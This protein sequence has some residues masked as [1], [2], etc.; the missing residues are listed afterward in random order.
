[1]PLHAVLIGTAIYMLQQ[2]T[3]S[4]CELTYTD[5]EVTVKTYVAV[6][7][8]RYKLIC[9]CAKYTY[10][11]TKIRLKLPLWIVWLK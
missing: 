8:N 11:K 1:M 10:V 4:D 6:Y 3:R 5:I 9:K 7:Y 2:W